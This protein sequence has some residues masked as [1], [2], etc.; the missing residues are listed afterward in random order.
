MN[1]IVDNIE[2]TSDGKSS[3]YCVDESKGLRCWIVLVASILMQM[4]L[5]GI[6]AWSIF[7]K[8]LCSD[9][10]LSTAQTQI[11]FGVTIA[12]FT[13][14]MVFAG[15]LQERKGPRLVATIGSLM[16]G[17]G[18]VLASFSGGSF[19]L[20]L[21]GIGV[22]G[23]MGIGFCYVCPLAT[24][25]KWFPHLKGLVTGLAVAGFG[26]GGVLLSYLAG[27]LIGHGYSVLEVFRI[28]GLMYG[29]ILVLC[30]SVMRVPKDSEQKRFKSIPLGQLFGQSR[31]WSLVSGMF[32]GTFAG[33]MVVGNVKPI[34]ESVGLSSGHAGTAIAALAV[35]NALGRICW[36]FIYDRIVRV[37]VQFSL[38]FLC[39][40]V[41]A[42]LPA[43]GYG[44]VFSLAAA[45]DFAFN[46]VAGRSAKGGE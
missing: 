6:Y 19:F 2:F 30:A 43:A 28:I 12:I 14:A 26:G 33:L 41:I 21:I 3:C 18:W 9:Y 1:K 32:C 45:L 23:G 29:V 25:V 27:R 11:V 37:T 35:G 38:L 10:G 46:F 36:G 31:F 44:A 17:V 13:T 22:I 16:F 7:V 40:A 24:C 34:G 8:P 39:C 5:G 4:C 20:I 42:L 15:R